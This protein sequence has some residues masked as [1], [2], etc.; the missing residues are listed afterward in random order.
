LVDLAN[1]IRQHPNIRL[2]ISPRG[3]LIWQ[4]VSQAWAL[5]HGRDFVIPD[6]IQAVAI[7][8]I[9]VRIAGEFESPD[10]VIHQAFDTIPVPR[11]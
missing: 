10:S 6:D 1:C 4:A 2:G 9:G 8:V 7:P 5:L 3:L 11:K